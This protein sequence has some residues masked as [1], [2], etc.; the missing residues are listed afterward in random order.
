MLIEVDMSEVAMPNNGGRRYV[1]AEECY[2]IVPDEQSYNIF[3]NDVCAKKVRWRKAVVE[4][5]GEDA[6]RVIKG[7]RPIRDPRNVEK[8]IHTLL[9]RDMGVFFIP[10]DWMIDPNDVFELPDPN[11]L[12][13]KIHQ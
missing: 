11:H 4:K 9:F 3:S 7:P 5:H 10:A 1:V 12:F 13:K 6:Y 2:V 8:E